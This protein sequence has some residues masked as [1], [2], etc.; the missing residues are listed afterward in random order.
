MRAPRI[1][2]RP[3]DP[4]VIVLRLSLPL[5]AAAGLMLP[6]A[7]FAPKALAPLFAVTAVVVLANHVFTRRALPPIP[8]RLGAALAAFL[9][10]AAASSAWSLT[11]ERTIEAAAPFAGLLLGIAILL[12]SV[13][14]PD[15]I[16]G[17]RV[18][19]ALLIG[20]AVGAGAL[21]IDTV[22][23]RVL[24]RTGLSLLGWDGNTGRFTLKPAAT[25]AALLAWPCL[26]ALSPRVSRATA[27]AAA[28]CLFAV[29]VFVGSDVA[30]VGLVLGG[31]VFFLAVRWGRAVALALGAALT[32]FMLSAP[33]I[34][35]LFP[36][37]RVSMTG[38]EYMPNSGVHRIAIWQTTAARIHER[39]WLGHG[40][41]TSRSLYPQST[42]VDVH[43]AKPT[44]GRSG[45]FSSEPI[46]LHPHNM[47][48]QIWLELGA[49]GAVVALAALL[50][51]LVGLARA[52]LGRMER[53]A[54]YGFFVTALT[55]AAVAYG[56]WQAWWLSALGLSAAVLVAGFSRAPKTS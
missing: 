27:L 18:G 37:P 3:T 50:S 46:P 28:A 20:V 55:I 56:A 23:D 5:A 39:P 32:I 25:V 35:S 52:P 40:F 9:L 41:D 49:V 8:A 22:F 19:T 31:A 15:E 7:A 17:T 16:A 21:L 48:L 33:W 12:G 47:I 4:Q 24:L 38:I 44:I 54:G 6:L 26:L 30:M 45:G 14:R 53:A 42:T 2:Q 51:I 10:L 13:N 36:D 43:F 11:P 29:I 1:A 34:P